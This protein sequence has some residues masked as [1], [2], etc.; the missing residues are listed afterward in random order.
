MLFLEKVCV[1]IHL[2]QFFIN[3][4]SKNLTEPLFWNSR[5]FL[6]IKKAVSLVLIIEFLSLGQKP[7][8]SDFY[9]GLKLENPMIKTRD[10][11]FF[12]IWKRQEFQNKG[13]VKFLEERLMKYWKSGYLHK[14]LWEKATFKESLIH[15]LTGLSTN[16][17]HSWLLLRQTLSPNFMS[18]QSI[19]KS[20]NVSNI[21]YSSIKGHF[22]L[23]S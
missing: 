22:F 6:I 10:T 13:S 17:L 16:L 7:M 3:F 12:I 23:R 14:P 4:S 2:L 18:F 21:Y 8:I 9:S 20:I 19:K 5:L 15:Y 11:A 1:N